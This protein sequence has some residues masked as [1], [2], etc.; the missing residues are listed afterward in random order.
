M[1]PLIGSNGL[2]L[3]RANP[4]A[5]PSPAVQ[6]LIDEFAQIDRGRSIMPRSIQQTLQDIDVG[7]LDDGMFFDNDFVTDGPCSKDLV[8]HAQRIA[9]HSNTCSSQ[10]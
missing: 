10:L 8:R 4:F 7:A 5:H 1:W 6:K 9:K 2:K 3:M